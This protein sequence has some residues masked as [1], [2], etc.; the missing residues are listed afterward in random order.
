ML[1]GAAVVTGADAPLGAAV[2]SSLAERADHLVLGGADAAEL[3][4]LATSLEAT[5]ADVHSL[6]TDVRDEFEVERL[7]EVAARRGGGLGAVVPAARVHHDGAR[8]DLTAGSYAAFDDLVRTNLR[9]VYAAVREAL[10]HGDGRTAIVIPAFEADGGEDLLGVGE[11]AVAALAEAVDAAVEAP[12]RAVTVE[13]GALEDDAGAA[14]A[15]ESIL[16]VL[17]YLAGRP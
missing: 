7:V 6:R 8:A 2:A 11:A 3:A 4:D 9:G 12:V 5:G 1:D 13:A 15:A 16:S 14:A 17:E 10:A